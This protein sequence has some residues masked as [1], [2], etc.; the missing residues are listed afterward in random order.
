MKALQNYLRDRWQAP[1]GRLRRLHNAATGEEVARCG[2][3]GVDFAAMV[4]HARRVGGPNL[5]R[6]TIHQ[7]AFMV[8]ALASALND[9]KDELYALNPATG[10]TRKDGLVDIDGGITT[11][12]VISSKARR[13]M[14]DSHV[15]IDGEVEQISRGG[16]FLAQHVCTPL[17]G[18]AVHINAFNFPVWGMLEKLAPTLIAGVP[19]I[20]KP[21]TPGAFLAE[22]AFRMIVDSGLLPEG[23]VQF[24][25]GGAGDLLDHLGSQDVVA[26]TGSADTANMLRS[27]PNIIESGVRFLAETD[28]LNGAILGPDAGPETPEFELFVKEVVRE[29]TVKAGQKCTAI[30]R[31]FVP[32]GQLDAVLAALTARLGK[33]TIGNPANDEVRMGALAGLDQRRDV[34]ANIDRLAAGNEIVFGDVQN[35]ELLDADAER[36]A[37]LPPVL[38]LCRDARANPAVHSVEAFGPVATVIPYRDAA[39]AVELANLG[40][41]SL[42]SSVFTHDGAFAAEIVAGIGSYHGRLYILNRDSAKEG[43]GHGSP[44]PHLVHGGPGRAGGGE[45]LGGVRGIL[46]YMQRTAVQ[47]SPDI[48]TAATGRWTKGAQQITGGPHPFTRAYDALEVG[49]TLVTPERKVTLE[50]IEH[51]AD[52]TGDTFYAHMDEAAAKANPFFEGRVAHGYLLLSFAAGLFVHPDPGPVL[53]NAGLDN[54]TFMKPVYPDTKIHVRLTVKDKTPRS[55]TYGQVR[56]DVEILDEEGATCAAYDLLTMNAFSAAMAD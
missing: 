25:A 43:T 8:K 52:F 21:A 37:F 10:A 9:R 14:P 45:E 13:G 47:G 36:G 42:V 30:R 38:L 53:A 39:D 27:R 34:L 12:F 49:E 17:K 40:D 20:I 18:V 51:F 41:G 50:D 1:E 31:A 29:M 23:A 16:S 28:S 44:L 33:V 7:R 19:A 56:W 2:T 54:L 4:E 6:M 11:M 24:I 26:F 5:R 46:K 15:H 22:A 55:E 32:E 3:D 48:L 35:F